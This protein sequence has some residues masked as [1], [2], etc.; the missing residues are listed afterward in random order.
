MNPIKSSVKSG[1]GITGILTTAAL[2]F[3]PLLGLTPEQIETLKSLAPEMVIL[4]VA[5][6]GIRTAYKAWVAHKESQVKIAQ[7]QAGAQVAT[8]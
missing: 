1:E 2:Y 6:M 3:A 7:I 8:P 5:F 4:V